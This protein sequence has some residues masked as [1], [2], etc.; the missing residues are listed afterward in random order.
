MNELFDRFIRRGYPETVLNKS[1]SKLFAIC[2][3]DLITP[4]SDL[5]LNYLRI[6]NTI[7]RNLIISKTP[8]HLKAISINNIYVTFPFYENKEL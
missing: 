7:P 6:H 5:L 4:K 2:R 3:E 8:E 1:R